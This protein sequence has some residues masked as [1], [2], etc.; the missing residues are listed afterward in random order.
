[1]RFEPQAH[2][3]TEGNRL[4]LSQHLGTAQCPSQHLGTNGTHENARCST[5]WAGTH[6]KFIV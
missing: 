2:P 6:L 5:L 1:M 3:K 4:H